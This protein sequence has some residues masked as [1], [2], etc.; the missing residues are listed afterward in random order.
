MNDSFNTKPVVKNRGPRI[1]SIDVYRGFVMVLMLLE[2][3]HLSS[4]ATKLKAD[5]WGDFWDWVQLHT[6]HCEWRGC[7]L[8]DLIQ[9][10][11]SFLVGASLA[12]SLRARMTLG[13]SSLSIL[14]H[15]ILR[16][17]ILVVLGVLLRSVGPEHNS[18]QFRF[19]DT[20]CQ[21]G[22]GYFFLVTIAMLPRPFT[23]FFIAMILIGYWGAF[24]AYPTPTA[25]FDYPSVGVPE[26][27]PHHYDGFAS[28]WNKNSNAGW[29]FDRWFMNLFP[30]DSEFLFS[31]GGYV[32]LSFIPTLATML[33]G[34]LA[35]IWLRDEPKAMNRVA[36]LA[37]ATIVCW[38]IAWGV[39]Y[40]GLCPIVKR[41]WTPTWTLWSGGWCFLTLMCFHIVCDIA[42]FTSWSYPLRVVGSNSIVAYVMSDTTAPFLH[43]RFAKWFSPL[44]S[45]TGDYSNGAIGFAVFIVVWLVLD[46]LHR[47]RSM[48]GSNFCT[49]VL[50]GNIWTRFTLFEFDGCHCLTKYSSIRRPFRSIEAETIPLEGISADVRHG[51][52]SR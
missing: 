9:P 10:G 2:M 50:R 17:V 30:R 37:A 24:A 14:L 47:K 12:Y 16:S 8:H 46:W 40:A 20:L 27:W 26:T 41:I 39:E 22:L 29:A 18:I 25:D 38:L 1:A 49:R 13:Q 36:Y 7:T 33:L 11:F 4:L 6:T 44:W 34:Y 43:D 48:S 15:T 23:Y 42:K 35:G 3:V 19:D 5:G 32:T 45:Y 31:P 28:H 52:R 51:H 21:I